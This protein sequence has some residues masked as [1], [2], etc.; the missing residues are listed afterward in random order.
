[1]RNPLTLSE[2]KEKMKKLHGTKYTILGKKCCGVK[3][4]VKIRHEYCG[5]EW[6]PKAGDILNKHTECPVCSRNSFTPKSYRKYVL[7]I[8]G[9]SIVVVDNYV[10]NKTP[11]TYKCLKH[12]YY[13]TRTP[14]SFRRSKYRCKLCK[15]EHNSM[16]QRKSEKQFRHELQIA[17]N[18]NII[19]VE[20]YVNTH[21]KITLKC[22]KCSNYWRAEPNSVL[23][24]SGCPYCK[25]SHGEK[26]IAKLLRSKNIKYVTPKIFKDCVY[27]RPLHYD[28]YLSDNNILI[29]YDG[30]QH[31]KSIDFFGG[32]K[33]LANQKV[34]DAIKNK[35][36]RNNGYTLIRIPFKNS[37]NAIKNSV[38]KILNKYI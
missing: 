9:W 22:L 2:Y 24:L 37:D 21:T 31:F 3:S 29:E 27:K 6:S 10:D 11:L 25:E 8:S 17:H 5:Y 38:E 18:N 7:I 19:S 35:Y 1:M 12:N 15:Y 34:K 28:F 36:A 30:L 32:D 20:R 16:V 33:A 26:V 23:R 4:K 14:T 13:F